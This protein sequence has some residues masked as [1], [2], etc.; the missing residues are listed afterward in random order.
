MKNSED[1]KVLF[2]ALSGIGNVIMQLSAIRELKKAHPTWHV[3]VWVAPRG[4]K[5]IVQTESA[6]DEIIEMPIKTS[7]SGHIR[8]ITELRKHNFDIAIV[9][10]PGQ[11]L[12][13]AAYLKLAGIPVRI[14]NTYPLRGNPRSGFLLTDAVEEDESLHDIEQNLLLLKPLGITPQPVPY[15][16]L[17]VPEEN[18]VEADKILPLSDN[19]VVGIHAGSAEGFE[20]KRWP[21]ENFAEAAKA[22]VKASPNAQVL[23]FGSKSEENQKQE[24]LRMINTEKEIASSIDAS[25][26]TTA[27]VIAK[28][29]LFISNDSGLMHI[30]AALGVPTLGLFGPT[31]EKKTGPRGK[32]SFTIRAS[33]TASIYNTEQAY[34]FGN[35]PHESM[36]GITA[37]MIIDK[38]NK[39]IL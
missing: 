21:L 15:Y 34:S 17:E 26:L 11:L 20:W 7:L 6:V 27:A 31:D 5:P 22:I 30:A 9:L 4:T 13:S 16:S 32:N 39:I 19:F 18:K 24:L 36:M 23:L 8:Q 1:K 25:L 38:V 2:L 3:T 10:S 28:C 14:G 37:Q 29:N 35:T 33:D 12:K